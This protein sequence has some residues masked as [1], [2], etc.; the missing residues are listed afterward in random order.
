MIGIIIQNIPLVK[1]ILSKIIHD[2]KIKKPPIQERLKLVCRAMFPLD[3]YLRKATVRVALHWFLA[4]F[5][6]KP[7]SYEARGV[8]GVGVS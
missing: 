8:W 6:V 5:Q 3:L 4:A 2:E 7:F 1:E